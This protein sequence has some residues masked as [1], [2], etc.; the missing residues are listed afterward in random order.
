MLAKRVLTADGT[1]IVLVQSPYALGD[2][3]IPSKEAGLSL[4]IPVIGDLSDVHFKTPGYLD[5]LLY[6]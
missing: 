6:F 5:L 1:V 3:R 4:E 2:W